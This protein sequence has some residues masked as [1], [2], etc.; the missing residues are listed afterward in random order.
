LPG[1]SPEPEI[2]WDNPSFTQ[3]IEP[4][5]GWND[6]DYIFDGDLEN[7]AYTDYR[8]NY[9]IVQ[10]PELAPSGVNRLSLRCA[11]LLNLSNPL[12]ADIYLSDRAGE[13]TLVSFENQALT[14]YGE[15]I[16][17]FTACDPGFLLIA[18]K[19]SLPCRFAIF[20]AKLGTQS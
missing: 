3:V 11:D 14:P 5:T 15:T 1:P 2:V 6:P 12:T 20:E 19:T 4:Y 13:N 9:L 16:L 18:G 10:R 8:E 17:E 7:Y